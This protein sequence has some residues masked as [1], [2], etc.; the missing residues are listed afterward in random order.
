MS[1]VSNTDASILQQLYIAQK[2]ESRAFRDGS[3]RVRDPIARGLLRKMSL[4]ADL[5][6]KVIAKDL[7]KTGEMVPVKI[8]RRGFQAPSHTY[9]TDVLT[10]SFAKVRQDIVDLK[11][12][13]ESTDS[14]AIQRDLLGISMQKQA[15]AAMLGKMI[16]LRV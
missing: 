6:A 9:G 3:L 13:M 11:Q 12:A 1:R 10:D 15:D 8:T 7:A 16:D 5:N 2:E 14:R 4:E